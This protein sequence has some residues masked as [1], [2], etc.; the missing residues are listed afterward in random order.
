MYHQ[1]ADKGFPFRK[2]LIG[3]SIQTKDDVLTLLIHLGYLTYDSVRK[4]VYVP[5]EEVRDEFRNFLSNDRFGG[6]WIKLI[7]RSRK[8]LNDTAAGN[9]DAVAAA[10]EEIRGEQYA[11]QYYN[12]KQALRAVRKQ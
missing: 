2:S 1:R 9:S 6:H 10:L 3:L 11:P 8:L 4:T 5:N 12:D 7:G